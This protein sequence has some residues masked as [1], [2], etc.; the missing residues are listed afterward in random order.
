MNILITGGTGLVGKALSKALAEAGHEVRILS[1]QVHKSE[2]KVFKWDTIRGVIDPVAFDGLNAMVHL[3]GASVA[4][5]RWTAERKK[6]IIHS[7]IDSAALL[8]REV[9]NNGTKLQTYITAS[10]TGYYGNRPL[11]ILNEEAGKGLGFLTDVCAQW[12]ASA[13]PF[14]EYGAEVYVNR[15]GIVLSKDGG[16]LEKL[17]PVFK[18]YAGSAFGSGKQMM[19]WIHLHD[20]VG[21]FM[22][23]IEGKLQ[24]GI[25]NAVTPAAVSNADMM[26]GIS[27]T[28]N[29][30]MWLPNVPAWALK[31]GLGELSS[32]L[33]ADQHVM[34]N[35]LLKQQY[36]FKYAELSDA[37]REALI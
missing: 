17:K 2:Y 11:E 26:A 1:R 8:L 27:K 24:S 16:F 37:L 13:L 15:I 31:I 18:W 32:E 6:E 33:L 34:P 20:L 29:R 4:E 35:Q 23:Q 10:G 30:K 22:A 19:S 25:Y 12:E 36:E 14:A 5:K 7:R 21:I 9:K 3:A 28:L